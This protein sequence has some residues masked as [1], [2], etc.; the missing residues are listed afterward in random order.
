MKADVLVLDGRHLLW[1]TSDA[2]R[3]LTAEVNGSTI[4]TGGIYG[5]LSVALRIHNR[6]G[7]KTF[8]AWEGRTNFRTALYPKYKKRHEERSGD[9]LELIKEMAI[10]ERLLIELLSVMGVRQF[11]GINYEADDVIG[12]IAKLHMDRNTVV[13][14]TGDSDLRQ[15]VTNSV[16]VV[17]PTTQG[18]NRGQDVV[19][20]ADKVEEK[21][22]VPPY[23]VAQLKALSGDSSDN[24]P[25]VP[26]V[27]PKTA[28]ILLQHYGSLRGVLRGAFE[29]DDRDWPSTQRFRQLVKKHVN[30]VVLYH[31]LTKISTNARTEMISA[32]RDRN[33]VVR[34]L[35]LYK[36][37]SL[38]GPGELY[39]LMKMGGK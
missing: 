37:R 18:K 13:I 20:D 38:C 19:Y 4:A 25:G 6:Y 22:G 10:Q 17:A 3:D 1:R 11:R 15:L 23:L 27:G 24:I 39:G 2:F 29:D 26:G 8:V 32:A 21:H 9:E 34:L 14:Y 16:L 28:A 36:F 35:M 7:G 33:E 30:E 31:K 12:T 5:F